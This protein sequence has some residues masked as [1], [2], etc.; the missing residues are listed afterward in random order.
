MA[1]VGLAAGK[2]SLVQLAAVEFLL[3]AVEVP[4][5][6]ALVLQSVRW[7]PPLAP[8]VVQAL[9]LLLLL[10][11]P[12]ELLLLPL[13]LRCSLSD[14]PLLLLLEASGQVLVFASPL[15]FLPVIGMKDLKAS[16]CKPLYHTL[17]DLV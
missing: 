5:V 9:P 16:G 17:L 15:P 11:P 6:V 4:L 7:G 2:H 3:L 14:L 1:L 10:R 12:F 13:L 8:V